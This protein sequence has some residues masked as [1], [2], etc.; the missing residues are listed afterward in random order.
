MLFHCMVQGKAHS[1]P[2]SRTQPEEVRCSS[3]LIKSLE[4][5]FYKVVVVCNFFEDRVEVAKTQ[6]AGATGA[7]G[8]VGME[9]MEAPADIS[10]KQGAWRKA[11]SDSTGRARRRYNRPRS[12]SSVYSPDVSKGDWAVSATCG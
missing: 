2:E 4:T 9:S 11:N 6:P 10:L 3:Q 12:V 7:C 5:N 1:G 8:C